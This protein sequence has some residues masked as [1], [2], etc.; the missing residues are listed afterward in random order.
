MLMAANGAFWCLWFDVAKSCEQLR[1]A[2]SKLWSQCSKVIL[3]SETID[4]GR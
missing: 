4:M 3:N 1:F 2:I